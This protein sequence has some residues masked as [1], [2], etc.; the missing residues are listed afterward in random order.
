MKGFSYFK[1]NLINE[2]VENLRSYFTN[3]KRFG[4]CPYILIFV[5]WLT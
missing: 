5:L 4:L 2:I 1:C 3:P